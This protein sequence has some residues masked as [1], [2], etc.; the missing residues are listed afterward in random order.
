MLHF[1]PA[2]L[3][4]VAVM[5]GVVVGVLVGVVV[6]VLVGIGVGV[7]VM[8]SVGFG[9]PLNGTFL[10]CIFIVLLLIYEKH[11]HP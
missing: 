10:A 4:G 7:L 3:V 1:A 5:V 9:V 11:L 2:V 6:G 8:V